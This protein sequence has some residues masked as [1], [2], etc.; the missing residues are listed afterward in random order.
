MESVP[1]LIG[2]DTEKATEICGGGG[3]VSAP[4]GRRIN[5]DAE[6]D[7]TARVHG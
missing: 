6:N 7:L 5:Q 1:T 4:C 3:G 2:K